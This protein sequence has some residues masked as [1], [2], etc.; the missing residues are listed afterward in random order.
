MS[1]IPGCGIMNN[2]FL[3]ETGGINTTFKK[4]FLNF[5]NDFFFLFPLLWC[6]KMNGLGS[7]WI[8]EVF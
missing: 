1:K 8:I 2:L 5:E 3:N 7:S 6:K 4:K